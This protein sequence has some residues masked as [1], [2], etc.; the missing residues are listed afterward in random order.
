METFPSLTANK[1]K[2]QSYSSRFLMVSNMVLEKYQV[3]NSKLL[4][5]NSSLEILPDEW[6]YCVQ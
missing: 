3:I 2:N 4:P 5:L 1:S 6:E